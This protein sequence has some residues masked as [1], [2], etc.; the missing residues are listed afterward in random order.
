M[1]PH[2]KIMW[3]GDCASIEE[4]AGSLEVGKAVVARVLAARVARHVVTLVLGLAKGA[5]HRQPLECVIPN[6][7]TA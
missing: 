7:E 2:N 4:S 3:G 6:E 1:V 5:E